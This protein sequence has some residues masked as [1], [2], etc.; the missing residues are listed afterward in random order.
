VLAACIAP[1]SW[2]LT[3][4]ESRWL[5]ALELDAIP[6]DQVAAVIRAMLTA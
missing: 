4:L 3:V 2:G 6:N 5:Q 1:I